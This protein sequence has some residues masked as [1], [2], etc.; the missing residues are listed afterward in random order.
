[1]IVTQYGRPVPLPVPSG[2]LD[3][4]GSHVSSALDQLRGYYGLGSASPSGPG[5]DYFRGGW[6]S[7]EQIC[8]IRVCHDD[9]LS[10][11]RRESQSCILRQNKLLCRLSAQADVLPV[12][13]GHSDDER[14]HFRG[15]DVGRSDSGEVEMM[16]FDRQGLPR[17]SSA[18]TLDEQAGTRAGLVLFSSLAAACRQHCQT[19]WQCSPPLQT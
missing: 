15:S 14:G 17:R 1:M 5:P 13:T 9:S 19:A 16:E 12:S 11:K 4:R 8:L 7:D 3:D 2:E 18:S 10:C 6:A